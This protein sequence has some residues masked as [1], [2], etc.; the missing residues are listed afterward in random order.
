MIAMTGNTL[1]TKSE[2]R[3]HS[4]MTFFLFGLPRIFTG[5]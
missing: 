1:R 3:L 2:S 5:D 4:S